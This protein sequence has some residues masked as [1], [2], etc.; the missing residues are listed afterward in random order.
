MVVA[1]AS[2]MEDR[3]NLL[4]QKRILM[5]LQDNPGKRFPHNLSALGNQLHGWTESGVPLSDAFAEFGIDD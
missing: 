1:T 4:V 5:D 3:R 2:V